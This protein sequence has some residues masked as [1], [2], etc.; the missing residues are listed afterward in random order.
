[1]KSIK[2]LMS[3][4]LLAAVLVLSIVP[5]RAETVISK[6]ILTDGNYC[7][8][9]F[10]SIRE[11]T[12]ASSRPVL[13]DTD[14]IVDFYGP[15]NHDPLGNEIQSQKIEMQHRFQSEYTD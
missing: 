1:V 5:A 7:H 4:V 10:E 12:L 15:C 3:A 13:K 11:N 6:D 2:S 8:M 9:K 14:D